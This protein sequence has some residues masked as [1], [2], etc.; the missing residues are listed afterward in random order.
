[1]KILID[2]IKFFI[3]KKGKSQ[4]INKTYVK[5][6][7]NLIKSGVRNNRNKYRRII[8]DI[9][10]SI[11]SKRLYESKIYFFLKSQELKIMFMTHF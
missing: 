3:S 4:F 6:K 11:K 1:M 8:Y 5:D 7:Y 10:I 9:I 2:F